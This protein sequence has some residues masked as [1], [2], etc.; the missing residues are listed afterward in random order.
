MILN[1]TRR[2]CP[3]LLNVRRIP[4]VLSVAGNIASCFP[5]VC[6]RSSRRRA[7][8]SAEI[9]IFDS[10][11]IPAASAKLSA[12]RFFLLASRFAVV[13]KSSVSPDGD[14]QSFT[15]VGIKRTGRVPSFRKGARREPPR[16]P[17]IEAETHRCYVLYISTSQNRGNRR[18]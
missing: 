11:E 15:G 9:N 3:H 18:R 13:I 6:L 7:A 16:V 5:G 14:F 17:P 10:S 8:P 4:L 1:N 2:P 12:S